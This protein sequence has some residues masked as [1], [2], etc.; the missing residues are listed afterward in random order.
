MEIGLLRIP[1]ESRCNSLLQLRRNC[2][3]VRYRHM[4]PS[5]PVISTHCLQIR[6]KLRLQVP[7]AL[8]ELRNDLHWS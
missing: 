2:L 1:D 8:F 4:S 6:Y 3:S 5:M 7:G